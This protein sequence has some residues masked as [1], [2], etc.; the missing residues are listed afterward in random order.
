MY[1]LIFVIKFFKI[2]HHL[3]CV[4]F[5]FTKLES[6]SYNNGVCQ[7]WLKLDKFS[8]KKSQNVKKITDGQT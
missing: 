5:H 6:P 4:T 3:K 1:Q 8:E 2:Y 7:D